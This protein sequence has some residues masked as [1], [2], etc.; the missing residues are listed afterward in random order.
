[1][2]A[3]AIIS[4]VVRNSVIFPNVTVRSWA[5]IEESVI[6]EGVVVG[7]HSRIKK[8]IIDKRNTIPAN[9]DI[10]YSPEE[11]RSR[12]TITPRGIVV[13]PKGYFSE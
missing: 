1:M 8:A 2:A 4:G 9:T 11:D 7:R 3:G 10:G 12:F 13:V 6:S 5:T